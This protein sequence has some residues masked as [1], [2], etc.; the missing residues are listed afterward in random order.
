M[1]ESPSVLLYHLLSKSS[2]PAGRIENNRGLPDHKGNVIRTFGRDASFPEECPA[3]FKNWPL[4]RLFRAKKEGYR[5]RDSTYVGGNP[6]KEQ[7][8][9]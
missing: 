1:K 9:P 6:S 8:F 5:Q 2:S 7:C 4:G 3:P